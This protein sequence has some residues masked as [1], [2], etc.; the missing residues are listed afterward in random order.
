M[1]AKKKVGKAPENDGDGRSGEPRVYASGIPVYCEHGEIRE[2]YE[3]TPNPR[4]PNRHGKRQVELLGGIIAANGW[5]SPIVISS[6]SGFIV[7]GEGRFRAALLRKWTEVPVDVQ[8]YA[9]AADEWAD[10]IADNRI[11]ELSTLSV[12]D[13]RV[14]LEEEDLLVLDPT[15]LGYDAEEIRT[16][17]DGSS[18]TGGDPGSD[19]YETQFGVIVICSDE[20]HQREVYEKLLD[21]G[22]AVKVVTT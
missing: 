1:T 6:R 13:L 16:I 21:E 9:T 7:K 3:L 10:L 17:V 18:G 15:V 20:T 11:S 2:I 8:E 22:Y 19:S 12:E 5:R 14:V 4:N